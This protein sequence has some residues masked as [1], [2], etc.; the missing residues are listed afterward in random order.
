[1]QRRQV[2]SGWI[3]PSQAIAVLPNPYDWQCASSVPGI[4]G[5]APAAGM[6]GAPAAVAPGGFRLLQGQ[7]QLRDYGKDWGEGNI[8]H[9]FCS[10]CGVNLYGHGY[11]AE[12]GGG[13]VSVLVNTLDDASIDELV[14]GPVHHADGRHDNWMNPPADTRAM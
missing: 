8:H 1:M 14:S 10:R 4:P 11:I 6:P 5:S 2:P 13:F 3:G 12:A 9:R 7:D